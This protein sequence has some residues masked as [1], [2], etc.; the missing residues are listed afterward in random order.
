MAGLATTVAVLGAGLIGCGSG[1]DADSTASGAGGGTT[2]AASGSN[3]SAASTTGT[4]STGTGSTGTGSTG[5]GSGGGA[6]SGTGSGT[7]GGSSFQGY[8]RV[9]QAG[10]AVK[11][12]ADVGIAP[13]GTLYVTWVADQ[14]GSKDVFVARSTDGGMSFGAAVQLDDAAT[15]PLVSMARHPYITADN[16]RV[17]VTF[18]DQAGAVYLHVSSTTGGLAFG[19]PI[20]VGTD[21]TTTFRDFPKPIFLGDGS[22]AVVWHGYPATGDRIFLSREGSGF[23]S[24]A[25]T[26]G[27]PG[28]PCEC[29]PNDVLR[30]ASGD[31][32]LAFRNNEANVREMWLAS[33]P[34]AGSFSSWSPIS[35]SEGTIAACPMQGPRLAQIGPS[36]H[37]AV[38]STRG[39]QGTG[40][41]YMARSTDGGASWSGG[42]PISGF[43]GDEPTIALGASG[44]IFVTGV[45]GSSSSAMV[46]SDDG[47]TV[48]SAPQPLDT[49]DGSLAVPQAEGAYGIAALAGVS[50]A[51][52]VWLRRME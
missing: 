18:N 32:L 36:E 46:S 45:T 19:A 31:L 27:A 37:L 30:S 29:C 23:A 44:R 28:V 41:A 24:V 2:T 1:S 38:W 39:P 21:I 43:T 9:D 5:T 16:D 11:G 42:A 33:A 7:G 15:V 40:S 47:G 20:L 35:T 48:W 22:I 34:A 14:G 26:G 17:A 51:G 50:S 52:T 49:P 12:S 25:A 10:S 13:D 3:G 4:G 8:T 6:S